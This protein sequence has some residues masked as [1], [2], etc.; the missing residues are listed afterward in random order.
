MLLVMLN[1]THFRC[2]TAC[3]SISVITAWCGF[4]VS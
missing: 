1:M 3:Y 2:Q 4:G